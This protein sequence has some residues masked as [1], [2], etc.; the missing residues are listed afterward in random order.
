MERGA[1]RTQI[2]SRVGGRVR[3]LRAIAGLTQQE[4]AARSGLHPT[5]LSGIERGQRNPSLSVIARVWEVLAE[6]LE[7]APSEVAVA[8]LTVEN[9]QMLAR[10]RGAGSSGGRDVP[11]TPPA[12]RVE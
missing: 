10:V 1:F 2:Q 9:Q 12:T 3:Q 6:A 7:M 5:Y 8:T 4:L 11:I